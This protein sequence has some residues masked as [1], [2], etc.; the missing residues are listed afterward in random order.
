[1]ED[2]KRMAGSY[3]IIQ[4]FHIGDREIVLG[5]DINAKPEERYMCAYCQ[6][7]EIAALYNEVIVSDDYCEAVKLFASR[8]SKQAEKTR[9]E[10]FSP[11]FQGI[12]MTPLS[13][14]DCTPISYDDDLHGKIV[15]IR[16]DVLRREYQFATR[17]LK[18]C[19]GGFG[20]S[21]HSRGSACFCIDLCSGKGSRFERRDILGTLEPEQ[22]PQ[23]A[24]LGLEQYQREQR[25]AAQKEE[26]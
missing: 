12:D 16:P 9:A 21:P 18:L 20:A 11:K 1:M 14:T 3:E 8:L 17:Q 23:W 7:S 6:Q 19:I 5:E 25:H 10:V 22:L 2:K 13:S 24:K 4:A 15:V 26:R